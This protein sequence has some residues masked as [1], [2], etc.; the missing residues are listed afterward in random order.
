MNIK[1]IIICILLLIILTGCTSKGEITMESDGSIK[2][3]V[4]IDVPNNDLSEKELEKQMNLIL[5]NYNSALELRNYKKKF[6]YNNNLSSVEFT[7]TYDNICKYIENNLF[8]QY[9]YKKISCTEDELYYEIKNETNHISYCIDCTT[10]P[11]LDN[12]SFSITLPIEAIESSS[13]IVSGNTYTWKFDDKTLDNK[14]FYLKISKE[15]LNKNI[16]KEKRKS[17][18]AN[19]FFKIII[20]LIILMVIAFISFDLVKKYKSK[21]LEY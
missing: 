16:I 4:V 11:S 17:N 9:L 14:E 18:F 6:I 3:K 5:D 7:N 1:K 10:W 15:S 21:N 13:D 19:V 12:V 8:T 2:E 20:P